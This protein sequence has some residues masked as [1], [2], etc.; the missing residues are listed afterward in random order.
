MVRGF[1]EVK[2]ILAPAVKYTIN[3]IKEYIQ[4]EGQKF[5]NETRQLFEEEK[6]KEIEEL[7][8]SWIFLQD[9]YGKVVDY[10][11]WFIAMECMASALNLYS[12]HIQSELE[13]FNLSKLYERKERA[14][15]VLMK[16]YPD[17]PRDK[18][19]LYFYIDE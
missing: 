10:S 6:Y 18:Y 7:Q 15:E 17:I 9:N 19:L 5:K 1:E 12:K 2:D 4:K 13:K 11:N 8:D 3:R 16:Y 14:V